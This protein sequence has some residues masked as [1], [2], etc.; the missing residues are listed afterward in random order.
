MEVMEKHEDNL[1]IHYSGHKVIISSCQT[2]H[3]FKEI[4]SKFRKYLKINDVIFIE[5]DEDIVV[6]NK[7]IA[8]FSKNSE[9]IKFMYDCGYSYILVF[10][11]EQILEKKWNTLLEVFS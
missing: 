4:F 2:D 6:I 3:S 9:S 10:K 8:H 1:I 7:S 5:T 11:D